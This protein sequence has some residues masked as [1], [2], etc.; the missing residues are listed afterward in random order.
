MKILTVIEA[1][2]ALADGKKIQKTNWDESF[3]V[4]LSKSGIKETDYDHNRGHFING[5]EFGSDSKWQ[6][7]EEPTS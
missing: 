4:Y 1:L 7:Y 6:L 5:D 2:K 3:Y